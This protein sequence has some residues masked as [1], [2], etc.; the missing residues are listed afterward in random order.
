MGACPHVH[1]LPLPFTYATQL[2]PTK[3]SGALAPLFLCLVIGGMGRAPMVK[4]ALDL[5][6]SPKALALL[7]SF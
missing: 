3:K 6:I 1:L 4:K 2:L 5:D 7:A